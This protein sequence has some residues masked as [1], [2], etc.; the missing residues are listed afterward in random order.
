MGN[1]KLKIAYI[2]PEIPALSATFVYNEIL[3]LEKRGATIFPISIR[4]PSNLAKEPGLEN[5]IKKTL[6]LY[7]QSIFFWIW[8]LFK[9]LVSSPF[10]TIKT[11]IVALQDALKVGLISRVGCGL[12]Y[13]F[14]AGVTASHILIENRCTHMHAHFSHVPTDISMYASMIS[15]IPFSF[16]SHAN[17]LF[18]RGWLLKEKI[19]RCKFAVTI[20]EFNKKFLQKQGAMS[21]KINV[22]HCGVFTELFDLPKTNV[23]QKIPIIGSLGR[24]VE[25]KGFDVLIKAS[26]RLKEEGIPFRLEIAGSGPLKESFKQLIEESNL[27]G[28]IS[29]IGPLQHDEVAPWL[30][31]LDVFALAAKQDSNNDMDGIPVVLMEAMISGVPVVSTNLSGIPE[32]VDDGQTGTLA[33]PNNPVSFAHAIKR[34]LSDSCWQKTL[35]EQAFKKVKSQYDISTNVGILFKRFEGALL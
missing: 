23:K 1:Q 20:S 18:E 27:T 5:L 6:V 12:L 24:F 8:A 3:E 16:T 26:E 21:G 25:K 11:F 4:E 19:D 17:D 28:E 14:F 9:S 31:R 30:K 7:N 32:L 35:I 33:E 22:I 10:R 29:L 15:G 2:A 34:I 13:R